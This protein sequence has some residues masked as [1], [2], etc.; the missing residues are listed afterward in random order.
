MADPRVHPGYR[1]LANIPGIGNVRFADANI[2]AKQEVNA[3]DLIM[4]DWDHDAY[5]YGK[6]E[7]SGS[8]SGPVT[9]TFVAGGGTG[10]L[11]W[12]L[13]RHG[14]CGTL[15]EEDLT[16]YYYC[17]TGTGNN[18]RQFVNMYVNSLGFSCAAGDVANF[19]LDVIGRYAGPWTS[20]DPPHFTDAEK[21]ITWDK[22]A[23][24]VTDG[25]IPTTPLAYSNFDL[26]VNNNIEAVYALNAGSGGIGAPDLFPYEVVPGLRTITGTLSV[27]DTPE[28]KGFDHWDDYPASDV[29]TL[30]FTLGGGAGTVTLDTKVRF[31]RIEPASSVTPIISTVGFTGV[32]HQT[33][34]PWEA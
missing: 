26:T 30:T 29:S 34:T 27:Y 23:V 5:V 15:T 25:G 14:N 12:A 2:T 21:L 10:L 33:G 17:G 1:G 4:G 31:H 32:S 18:S 3:P 7:V 19:T 20:G 9:E 11:G 28:F 6:V 16:L 13:T 8:I 22:V 24:S